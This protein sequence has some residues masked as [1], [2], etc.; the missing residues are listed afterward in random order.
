MSRVRLSLLFCMCAGACCAQPGYFAGGYFGVSTLSA[1]ARTD[2]TPAGARFSS[3]KPENGPTAV[4]FGGLHLSDFFSVMG[5]Y[6][7]SR[8][9]ALLAGGEAGAGS[10][11]YSQDYRA[12]IHTVMGEGMVYF[13]ARRSRVR[14]YLS[15]GAGITHT[16]AS[17]RGS[18]TVA[19]RPALPDRHI[20]KTGPA[21]RV[22]VG[23]DLLLTRQTAFRYSFSETI[24]GN[25]LSEAL[26][27]PGK[28][29]LAN[30]QNWFGI[31]FYF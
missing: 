18:L 24:Q 26:T 21:F 22:A 27:P 19:G 23:I 16:E 7:W 17:A 20:S 11:A 1:D 6:G 4:G 30:F 2:V 31:A 15:A 14:P 10:N 8:N 13:R 29:K 25:P 5:S 12:N 28:R 3:Y 9:S